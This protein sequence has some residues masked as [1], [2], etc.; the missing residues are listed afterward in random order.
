MTAR[1]SETISFRCTP[2]HKAAATQVAREMGYPTL[3]R[4]VARLIEREVVRALRSSP[5]L[6]G[7]EPQQTNRAEIPARR[8]PGEGAA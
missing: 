1:R 4:W 2:G 5:G 6:S 8:P 7:G 3:S